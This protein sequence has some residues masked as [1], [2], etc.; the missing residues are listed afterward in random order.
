VSSEYRIV[1]FD[2]REIVLALIEHA[3]T[4]GIKL[5]AGRAVKMAIDRG[6]FD[7][8]LY[9]AKKGEPLKPVDFHSAALSQALIR[10][11]KV[12]G[13][14][15]PMR[16]HKELRFMEGRVAFVVQLERPATDALIPLEYVGASK[17]A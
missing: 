11:C 12:T 5:P 1:F 9:Y 13:V 4:Q 14:P 3:R 15:L 16:A 6:T 17:G 8:K 7:V 10:H 2:D